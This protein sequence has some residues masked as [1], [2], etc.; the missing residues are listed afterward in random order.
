MDAVQNYIQCAELR[1]K[2]DITPSEYLELPHSHVIKFDLFV[3]MIK[4]EC[5]DLSCDSYEFRTMRDLLEIRS[6]IGIAQVFF[7]LENVDQITI[8]DLGA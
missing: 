1:K 8:F 2:V 3:D 6:W 4:T 7:P 5:M